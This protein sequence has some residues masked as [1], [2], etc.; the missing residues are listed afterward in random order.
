M[1]VNKEESFCFC[2]IK[3]KIM[4]P[5]HHIDIRHRR[6]G[7]T[8]LPQRDWGEMHFMHWWPYLLMALSYSSV[9]TEL[10]HTEFGI[11]TSHF[12]SRCRNR[13]VSEIN[14]VLNK[15]R[16]PSPG[17]KWSHTLH[18]FIENY[19][20]SATSGRLM[21]SRTLATWNKSI[22]FISIA[23]CQNPWEGEYHDYYFIVKKL[24]LRGITCFFFMFTYPVRQS[25]FSNLY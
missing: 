17:W 7:G 10:W 5:I 20:P 16:C 6:S 9:S 23:F 15:S 8:R 24:S 14:A 13:D 11:P 21:S 4:H 25:T 2:S 12:I 18:V 3:Q 1:K 22:G 19:F